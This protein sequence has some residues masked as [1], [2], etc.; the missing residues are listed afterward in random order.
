MDKLNFDVDFVEVPVTISGEAYVLREASGKATRTW[1]DAQI[2]CTKFGPNGKPSSIAGIAA[3]E[4]LLVSLCLFKVGEQKGERKLL[5]VAKA[6][7]EDFP[8]RVQNALFDKAKEISGLSEEDPEQE[9][10]KR[11]L[12]RPDAPFPLEALREWVDTLG[13]E[14]ESLSKFLKPS[15]EEEAKNEQSASTDGSDSRQD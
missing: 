9:Q 10:L 2:A 15:P 1:R 3:T 5:P 13:E 6:A 7:I 14:Y 12:G 11:A 4:A 8:S